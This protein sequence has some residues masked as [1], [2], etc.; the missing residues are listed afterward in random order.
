MWIRPADSLKRLIR[1]YQLALIL[2]LAVAAGLGGL[3]A[4]FWQAGYQASLRFNGLLVEAQ[5]VRGDLYR[6]IKAVD[7]VRDGAPRDDYWQRLYRIDEHFYRMREYADTPA[8]QASIARME[9]AYGLILAAMNR[10]VT[11]PDSDASAAATGTWQ[12]E[13]FEAAYNR[14]TRQVAIQRDELAERLGL[15]NRLAP[16]LAWLPLIL[17]VALA[18]WL[19][20]RFARGFLQPLER[21]V[22]GTAELA[23]G[24]LSHRLP[25]TG[26]AEVRQLADTLNAMAAELEHKRR[27]LIERERQ[28]ALGAL[29]PVIAH[30]IRNPLAGIRANAQMLDRQAPADEIE[31]TGADIMDAA[32]RLE[33]WLNALLS[34]LHPLDLKRERHALDDIVDGAIA[35]LGGRLAAADITLDRNRAPAY[36]DVDAPLL[37]QA[38]HGLLANA[39]E[40]SPPGASLQVA[41]RVDHDRATLTICDAGPGM[42]VVP[43][44]QASAPLPT[45]KRRGTGLGI[46]FAYKVIHAHDGELNYDSAPGGGTRVRVRLPGGEHA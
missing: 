18:I 27:A 21:L 45:T 28:A 23:S 37:E 34:Y 24:R 1:R 42:A 46:P 31:E 2:V 29:V 4:S 43:D 14:L 5:A 30:N 33:R 9:T 44:P 16:W 36:V 19:N 35:A 6:Q 10:I 7:A 17:G 13:D 8:E 38:L 25:N 40:A 41:T 26:V 12:T 39:L 20:R 15:W 22:A 3:W 11:T 32:D